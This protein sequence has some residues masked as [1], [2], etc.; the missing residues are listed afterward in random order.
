MRRDRWFG[1]VLFALAACGGG[2]RAT[3]DLDAQLRALRSENEQQARRIRELESRTS[4]CE[5]PRSVLGRGTVRIAESDRDESVADVEQ[6]PSALHEDFAEPE[7]SVSEDPSRPA[8]RAQGRGTPP[9]VGAPITVRED[10]RRPVVPQPPQT[11]LPPN[12]TPAPQ[13]ATTGREGRG[14]S[15][16]GPEQVEPTISLAAHVPLGEG[17]SSVRD[18]RSTAAYESALSDARAGHCGRAIEG[19]ASVLVRWPDHP[20]APSAMYWRGECL[21]SVGDVRRA[22]EQFEATLARSSSG[23]LSAS[24]LFKL[25]QCHR[26]LGDGARARSFT[27]R[28]LRE[29]ASTEPAAR[30]RLEEPR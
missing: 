19:L 15:A 9:P 30:A 13:P 23:H 2:T 17:T 6:I 28:L 12:R 7:P 11:T 8:L 26:R 27:D 4:A 29:Y 5:E 10:D 25:A 21:L 22:V 3:T 1:G 14:P 24:A 20:Q 16:M 18:P